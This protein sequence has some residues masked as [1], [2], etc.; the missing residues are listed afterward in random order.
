MQKIDLNCD[1]GEGTGND[2]ALM[3]F[4]SSCSIACGG[5]FGNAKTIAATL[6]LAAQNKVKTGAHPAYPDPQNFGRKSMDLPLT[7]LQ[8]VL[9]EQLD[10]FFGLCPAV[11][12]IKPHGA[13]YNDLFDEREKA[14]AVVEVFAAY[15]PKIKVYCAP[16][17]ALATAAKAAGLVP[18]LEGFGD[19]AYQLSG[20]LVPR[21]NPLA[22]FTQKEQIT[23]QV[24]EIIQQAE[25]IGLEGERIPL[26]INTIC[27][28]GDGK[29]V[30]E[31]L[32]YLVK[33]LKQK[34]IAVEAY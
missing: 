32:P 16:K 6:A 5:H 27:L 2:A 23:Q 11:N 4:I 26:K 3:P 28:H 14:S 9:R 19:R 33:T 20:A 7:E 18:V 29:N 1:V 25:V 15:N 34:N 21:K 30:Q 13:L 22:T 24:L 12:H 31:N 10:L 8:D 17:S